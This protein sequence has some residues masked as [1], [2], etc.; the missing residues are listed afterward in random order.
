M[1]FV[2]LQDMN[3][4]KRIRLAQGAVERAINGNQ[5]QGACGYIPCP[6]TEKLDADIEEE[7]LS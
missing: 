4:A 3:P 2:S 6:E 1:E 7:I 5:A